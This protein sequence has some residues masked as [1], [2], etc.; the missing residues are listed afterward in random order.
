MSGQ[1]YGHR[2]TVGFALPKFVALAFLTI[3]CDPEASV[4]QPAGSRHSIPSP[5]HLV[6]S[7][8]PATIRT[9]PAAPEPTT[10]P[11]LPG[12]KTATDPDALISLPWVGSLYWRCNGVAGSKVPRYSTTVIMD[13]DPGATITAEYDVENGEPISR[14]LNPP[15]QKLSTP[16]VRSLVHE[17]T[18]VFYHKPERVVTTIRAEFD[19]EGCG[20]RSVTVSVQR[21]PN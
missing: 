6:Q 14:R 11:N 2:G 19:H 13:W 17:W 12:P 21:T 3:A 1:A 8:T 9:S 7:S 10:Y 5:T 4:G 20:N 15:A 18:I 16:F